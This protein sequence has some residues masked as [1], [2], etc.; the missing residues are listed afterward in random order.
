[1]W[2]KIKEKLKVLIHNRNTY[3]N[4]CVNYKEIIKKQVSLK[5]LERKRRKFNTQTNH[6]I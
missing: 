3:S 6:L 5:L 2:Q 4:I 1:M